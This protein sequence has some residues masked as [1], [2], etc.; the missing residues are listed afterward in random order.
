[1]SPW[2]ENHRNEK[3]FNHP[4][5]RFEL[6]GA[7]TSLVYRPA[8]LRLQAEA[9]AGSVLSECGQG[10]EPCT[11]LP[12]L[13]LT[14]KPRLPTDRHRILYAV[15]FRPANCSGSALTPSSAVP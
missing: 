8:P 9:R 5:Q 7:T 3:R 11:G 10:I 1:M 4:P 15:L 14:I 12:H 13:I 6:G 2:R